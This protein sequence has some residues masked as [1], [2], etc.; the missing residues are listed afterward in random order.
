MLPNSVFSPTIFNHVGDISLKLSTTS[1]AQLDLRGS[2]VAVDD[3][4]LLSDLIQSSADA[5]VS[6]SGRLGN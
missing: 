6:I 1:S 5:L 4:I 3:E 2:S